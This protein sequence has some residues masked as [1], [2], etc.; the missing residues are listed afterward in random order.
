MKLNLVTT[1][2]PVLLQKTQPIKTFDKKTKDIVMQMK[3]I[4]NSCR[5]PEGVGLAAPQVGLSLSIFITKP[6]PQS[7][8]NTYINPKILQKADTFSS[9][10]NTLE[11]CL[12]IRNTWASIVR[13]KW[14]V[15]EY[16]DLEGKKK[17][18]KFTGWEAQIILHEMD[19]LSGILFTKLALNQNKQLYKIEKNTQGEEELI[20]IEI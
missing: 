12:S 2:N 3:N 16:Q 18:Q 11:G 8:I 5:D 19:H 14:V 9:R 7:A 13:P 15:L 17:Q 10:K 1:P 4:L 6:Y 20:K